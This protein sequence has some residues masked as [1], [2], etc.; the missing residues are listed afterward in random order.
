MV[1]NETDLIEVYMSHESMKEPIRSKCICLWVFRVYMN[2]EMALNERNFCVKNIKER[3]F[4]LF[5]REA[6]ILTW[7]GMKE[8]I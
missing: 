4:D 2:Q 8:G 7:P 1:L 3:I 6:E 5:I